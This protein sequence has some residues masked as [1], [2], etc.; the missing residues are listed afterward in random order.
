MKIE[1]SDYNPA[2]VQLFNAEKELILKD[3][4][5]E[6]IFIEHIGSTAIP[7]LKAK[8]VIDIL[9]GLKALPGEMKTIADHLKT[10][11]YGYIE[12]YNTLM[13]E[14]RFFQKEQNGIRTHQIHMVAMHSDFWN[15]HLFFRDYLRDNHEVMVQYQDL[16]T[17]LTKREWNSVNDYAN[18]K[19]DFINAIERLR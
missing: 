12:K 7:G 18:A 2:W 14:R 16:K 4:P 1:L 11:G 3:F 8:P 13:P 17:E 6:S 10:R 15:R 19:T 5:E 9:A